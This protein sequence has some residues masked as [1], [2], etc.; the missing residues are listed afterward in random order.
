MASNDPLIGSDFA[1]YKILERIKPGG[2]A[3]VYKAL[4]SEREMTIALKILQ[5]N[6]AIYPEV[7]E[8]F[9]QEAKLASELLHPNIVQFFKAGEYDG[10]LYIAMAYMPGGSLSDRITAQP[11]ITLG[12]TADILEQVGRALTFAHNRNIVHRDLKL[13]NI[14]LDA[15]DNAMLTDFG[16]ARVLDATQALTT[17]GQ[18]MPGTVKYMSPE[19]A[20]GN[21]NS[22]DERSDLYSFGV[23]AYLLSVG[24]YPFTGGGDIIVINQHLNMLPPQPTVVNPDL[25]P[26]LDAVL[27]RALAKDPNDRY[28]TA[29]EFVNAYRDA[30][31]ERKDTVV[32]VNLRA[33]NPGHRAANTSDS[34]YSPSIPLPTS[35]TP[36]SATMPPANA[37]APG[38]IP[39]AHL[40]FALVLLLLLGGGI[41]SVLVMENQA[42][43]AATATAETAIA[44][45]QAASATAEAEVA[46]TGTALAFSIAQETA[47]EAAVRETGTAQAAIA[48]AMTQSVTAT[49]TPTVTL[50]ATPTA[51]E[52]PTPTATPTET[53][54]ATPTATP[55][56]TAT[57]TATLT[58]TPTPTATVTHTPTPTATSTSTATV[59][60]SRT[61]SPT[62]R[63]TATPAPTATLDY[64]SLLDVVR[65]LRSLRSPAEFNCVTFLAA[66]A[67][68]DYHVTAG[69]SGYDAG[70]A[71]IDPDSRLQEIRAVCARDPNNTRRNVPFDD[72]RAMDDVLR[73]LEQSLMQP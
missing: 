61:A 29:S 15:N 48:I 72:Y 65:V 66:Y 60:P 32:T 44:A 30:V 46:M 47:V 53:P 14:L 55:S 70:R 28:Q 33:D 2:M 42:S 17:T 45:V 43:S 19:Q 5:D 22:L 54:S 23:I 9:N 67:Y 31:A 27:L 59:T 3:I 69:I 18:Q 56:A 26:A 35:N 52:T 62:P 63:I 1:T 8:R 40:I 73:D 11:E 68:L 38:R 24:R 64:G 41:V 36:S 10:R 51:T 57:P 16:I 49:F 58:P 50:S 4:D 21:T 37:T 7:V 13:G 20:Q 39:V 6:L 34:S 12:R 25:P 71:L